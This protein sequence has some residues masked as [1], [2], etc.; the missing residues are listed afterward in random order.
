M[1]ILTYPK[2]I[3]NLKSWSNLLFDLKHFWFWQEKYSFLCDSDM[4]QTSWTFFSFDEV[5]LLSLS[6]M[7]WL[8]CT[9]WLLS[10]ISNFHIF[11][12]INQNR[13]DRMVFIWCH[14][15]TL[16][17]DNHINR[18]FNINDPSF[19]SS[20]CLPV[21]LGLKNQHQWPK[22]LVFK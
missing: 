17:V 19:W 8:C 11:K 6:S 3:C 14:T 10:F 4:W 7:L 22:F 1:S 20:E 9:T 15:F 2:V 18:Q 21:E 5:V 12:I 13:S 16:D